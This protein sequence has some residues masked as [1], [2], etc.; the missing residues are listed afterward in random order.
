MPFEAALRGYNENVM[1]SPRDSPLMDFILSES[2]MQLFLVNIH[3][4]D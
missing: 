4:R 3:V 1:P 2:F